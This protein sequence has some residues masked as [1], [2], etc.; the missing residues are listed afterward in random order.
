MARKKQNQIAMDLPEL[1]Q[2][3]DV[4]YAIEAAELKPKQPKQKAAEHSD[5]PK[6]IGKLIDGST[7][8]QLSEWQ[9]TRPMLSA[10]EL[11][12][13][14]LTEAGQMTVQEMAD[15]INSISIEKNGNARY[16]NF[17]LAVAAIGRG[18]DHGNIDDLRLR[19]YSYLELTQLTNMKI[20]NM[21]AYLSIGMTQSKATKL[22]QNGTED[23]KDL[24]TEI[25]AVCAG[26]RE[27]VTADGK[28]NPVTSIFWQ[29]NFDNMQDK[30]EQV[31]TVNDP[32]GKKRSAE[33]IKKK[34]ED[35]IV[36]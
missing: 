17:T 14:Y 8:Q 20:S 11:N 25:Q 12:H 16:A 1:D 18:A 7:P 24:L 32:L 5:L 21:T 4:E 6:S 9:Q 30:R 2:Q 31:V 26:Y 36:G 19:F 35:I 34:Y 13:I 23:M 3:D 27:M 10:D 22:A 33:E 15:K 28:L 29:K